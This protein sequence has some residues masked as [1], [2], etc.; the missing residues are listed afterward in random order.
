M[1]LPT[2]TE[3]AAAYPPRQRGELLALADR[4]RRRSEGEILE[5]AAIAAEVAVDRMV[6]LGLAPAADPQLLEAFKLQ[7]PNVEPE[8][9]VG[10]SDKYLKKLGDNVKGKYFEVLV[11]DRLNAGES[12]GELQLEPGQLAQLAEAPNQ[13]GWD[14]E[15][16]DRHGE[17]V[18]QIQLKATESLS[19]VK[20]ALNEYPDIRVA[21]PE[22]GVDSEPAEIIGTDISHQ[23]LEEMTGEQLSELSEGFLENALEVAAELGVDL[24]PLSSV[25]LIGVTEGRRYLMGPATLQATMR[26]GGRRLGRASAY[27]ALSAGL[28]AS[29]FGLA[30]VPMVMGLRVAE[31][32]LFAQFSLQDNLQTRSA[33]L[34]GLQPPG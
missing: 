34:N 25:L 26:S 20:E 23:A 19:Y 3:I 18:E 22:G 21:V 30:A 13:P 24:I 31:A 32:R 4:Y 2:L 11:R 6:N 16:L 29:G 9:L 28:V 8:S 17:P 14:L 15:I 5:L 7:C 27:N 1:S 33:E 12:V 10:K